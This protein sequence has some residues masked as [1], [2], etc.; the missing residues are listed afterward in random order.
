[1]PNVYVV[2]VS[3]IANIK[4]QVVLESLVESG[5]L[6]KLSVWWQKA[7]LLEAIEKFRLGRITPDAFKQRCD[8]L[9]PGVAEMSLSEFFQEWM[10]MFS[11][12]SDIS[13]RLGQIELLSQKDF[14]IC[15]VGNI[16]A[17]LHK[18]I[19]DALNQFNSFLPGDYLSFHCKTVSEETINHILALNSDKTVYYASPPV[20]RM[21]YANLGVFGWVVAPFQRWF[22]LRETQEAQSILEKTRG[23]KN[24]VVMPLSEAGN[25]APPPMRERKLSSERNRDYLPN[26]NRAAPSIPATPPSFLDGVQVQ[27]GKEVSKPL[28]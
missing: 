23:A 4:E 22:H 11:L 9:F 1:M 8:E 16:D 19:D 10:K 18:A 15:F 25:F 24:F 5:V 21:P 20:S 7:P 17:I 13:Y 3:F 14:K 27:F 12:S 26:Y 2:P 28:R 6:T